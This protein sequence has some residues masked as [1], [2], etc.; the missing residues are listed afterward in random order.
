MTRRGKSAVDGLGIAGTSDIRRQSAS[1]LLGLMLLVYLP[2]Y[3][4]AGQRAAQT[5]T[6]VD[7]M[8]KLDGQVR[9]ETPV[10]T[11]AL[12]VA[13]RPGSLNGL[14]PGCEALLLPFKSYVPGSLKIDADARIMTY[15]YRGHENFKTMIA[16]YLSSQT[17]AFTPQAPI[18]PGAK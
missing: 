4:G 5:A 12:R 14:Q 9:P 15:Q 8:H 7:L 11:V 2:K 16:F 13:A 6:W 17:G 10:V 1:V 3:T 18:E